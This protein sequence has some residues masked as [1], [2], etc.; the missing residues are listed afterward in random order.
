MKS[1]FSSFLPNKRKDEAVASAP[2]VGHLSGGG[3]V[4]SSQRGAGRRATIIWC[5]SFIK[6][7]V[8]L[9]DFLKS[10]TLSDLERT[11]E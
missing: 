4:P 6:S 1:S 11:G 10:I 5:L 7:I 2:V 8:V 3:V 9:K